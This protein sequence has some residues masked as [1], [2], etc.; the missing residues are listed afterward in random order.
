MLSEASFQVA[1]SLADEDLIETLLLALNALVQ[2]GTSCLLIGSPSHNQRRPHK[3]DGAED[4]LDTLSG[5]QCD[6]VRCD[7]EGAGPVHG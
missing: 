1:L 6:Q 2:P 5:M 4:A 7:S 3:H